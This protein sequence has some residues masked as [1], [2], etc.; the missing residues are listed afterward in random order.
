MS[1]RAL[2]CTHKQ[3]HIVWPIEEAF[4]GWNQNNLGVFC[5]SPL[6]RRSVSLQ[7]FLPSLSHQYCLK[8]FFFFYP[9]KVTLLFE[10]ITRK[11]WSLECNFLS[12]ERETK[13]HLGKW[14]LVKLNVLLLVMGLMNFWFYYGICE[15][16]RRRDGWRERAYGGRDMPL[17]FIFKFL[18]KA[19]NVVKI[20]NCIIMQGKNCIMLKT[21]S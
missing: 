14:K 16:A 21:S 17:S 8:S 12:P 11:E 1:A 13:R 20:H 6:W 19:A 18:V 4:S 3:T 10:Q 9:V 15:W 5:R 2:K 7:Y